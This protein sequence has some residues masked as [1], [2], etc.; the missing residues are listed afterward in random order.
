MATNNDS[1][2]KLPK[3]PAEASGDKDIRDLEI[4]I[5]PDGKGSQTY[6]PFEFSEAK[7]YSFEEL[8]TPMG[9][10]ET[11]ESH[12]KTEMRTSLSF[13]SREYNIGGHSSTHETHVETYV[14]DTHKL[15]VEGDSAKEIGQNDLIAIAGQRI[16]TVH[17]GTIENTG[18]G[19]S[20]APTYRMSEGD[21]IQEHSGHYHEAFE[22]DYVSS[23]EQ[24]M[25]TMVKGG[26]QATHVQSG[27]WD[28]HVAQKSRLYSNLDMLLES[29]TKITLKV[30]ASTI[31]IG[32]A[33]ITMVSPRIDLN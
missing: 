4:I 30:G 28:T 6:S 23:V 5:R 33:S 12:N 29:S 9:S 25:I 27:N 32:P 18:A 31:V 20:E 8:W 11:R 2:K 14:Q 21:H 24:N 10:Y 13:E 26:D 1:N 19:A 15:T 3:N 16:K 7:Q 17:G 22:K